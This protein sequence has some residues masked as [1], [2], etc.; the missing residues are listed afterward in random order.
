MG[1][2]ISVLDWCLGRH[3]HHNRIQQLEDQLLEYE[4]TIEQIAT[5]TGHCF[6]DCCKHK[7]NKNI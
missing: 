5:S 7:Q 1:A 3:E 4:Y 2:V 6:L